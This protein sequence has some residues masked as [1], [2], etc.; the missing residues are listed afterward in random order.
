MTIEQMADAARKRMANWIARSV[1]QHL[2]AM[3][4]TKGMK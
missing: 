4:T 3:R 2:R 1:G